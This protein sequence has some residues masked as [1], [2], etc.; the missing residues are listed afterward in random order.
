MKQVNI[1][2]AV[3]K[4]KEVLSAIDALDIHK[5]IKAMSAEEQEAYGKY[6]AELTSKLK[7]LKREIDPRFNKV[8]DELSRYRD[9][10]QSTLFD[11][12]EYTEQDGSGISIGFQQVT[13]E[14]IDTTS[15]DSASGYILSSNIADARF[16]KVYS[17]PSSRRNLKKLKE[18]LSDGTITQA[19]YDGIVNKVSYEQGS[20]VFT[21]PS[22]KKEIN[23]VTMPPKSGIVNK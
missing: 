3:L 23:L 18:L 20:L 7:T 9:S 14:K 8:S 6:L 22:D 15:L 17:K 13:R 2:G 11:Y 19:E 16:S 21:D 10:Q 5:D 1:N 4:L 12:I